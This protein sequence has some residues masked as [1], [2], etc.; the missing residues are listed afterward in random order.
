VNGEGN[1]PEALTPAEERLR[2]HLRLLREDTDQVDASLTER[3]V[4]AARWQR[5]L[6]TPLRLAG[7]LAAALGEGIVVLL[8][9]RA[10]TRR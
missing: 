9:G 10:R 7:V 1:P 5:A 2:Q 3:V 6:R 8:G 4:R